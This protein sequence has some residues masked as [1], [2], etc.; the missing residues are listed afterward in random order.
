MGDLFRFYRLRL[1]EPKAVT[2]MAHLLARILF[3]MVRDR[4]AYDQ[5]ELE[6]MQRQQD[7]RKKRSLKKEAERMGF[8]LVAA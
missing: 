5:T 2:A 8:N 6:K 3:V 7:E 4:K 1:G